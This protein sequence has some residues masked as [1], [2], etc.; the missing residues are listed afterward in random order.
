MDTPP[1]HETRQFYSRPALSFVTRY[2]STAVPVP[3]P[4]PVPVTTRP[5]TTRH[6][7]AQR[8]ACCMLDAS[9]HPPLL[10]HRSPPGMHTLRAQRAACCMLDA[11]PLGADVALILSYRAL[12]TRVSARRAACSTHGSTHGSTRGSTRCLTH[13]STPSLRKPTLT[14]QGSSKSHRA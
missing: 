6:A 14:P 2:G 12:A 3:V 13:G 8:A 10:R 7:R 9:R 11:A 4:V 5:A 1:A